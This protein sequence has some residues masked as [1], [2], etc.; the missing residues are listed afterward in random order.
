MTKTKTKSE[1]SFFDEE[2]KPEPKPVAEKQKASKPKPVHKAALPAKIEKLPPPAPANMLA[3]IANA[4]ASP[5]VDVTKMRELLAMQREI[6]AE[7][8][9]MA[10]TASKIELQPDLPSIGRDGRIVIE[11][12]GKVIQKTPYATFENMMK[13][14]GPILNRYGF[15]FWTEPDI[16]ED[17]TPLIMRGHLDHVRGHGKTCRIPL[18]YETSGSKNNV[19]GIGSSLSYGRRYALIN[20]CNIISHAVEDRDTDGNGPAKQIQE[21]EP[22]AISMEQAQAIKAKMQECGVPD[23]K[24]CAHYGVNAVTEIPASKFNDVIRSC[25]NYAKRAKEA[26]AQSRL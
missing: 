23:E 10:F 5:S 13:V 19:Q 22:E 8:A 2:A 26:K 4:A 11:K 25:E 14:V 24:V 7:E 20:L 1:A 12:N 6:M 17:G 3:I 9:R 18:P 21:A 15:D 16:G